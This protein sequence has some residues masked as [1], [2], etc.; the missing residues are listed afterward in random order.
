VTIVGRK[1]EINE[2]L[3]HHN[4][5]NILIE[6]YYLDDPKRPGAVITPWSIPRNWVKIIEAKH[7]ALRLPRN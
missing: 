7:A 1:S 3:N 6:S 5:V 4:D 2:A